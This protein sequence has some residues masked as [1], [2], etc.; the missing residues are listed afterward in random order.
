M[1][2]LDLQPWIRHRLCRPTANIPLGQPDKEMAEQMHWSKYS[3]RRYGE[4][5]NIKAVVTHQ[6]GDPQQTCLRT[7]YL[8]WVLHN[9][10]IA[11]FIGPTYK[12]HSSGPAQTSAPQILL[13]H[14]VS[15]TGLLSPLWA[16]TAFIYSFTQQILCHNIYQ[17]LTRPWDGYSSE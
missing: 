7:W 1:L 5:W 3:H 12:K 11:L 8:T 13:N 14:L 2:W 10:Q 4:L 17:E 15:T 9:R 6:S 16:A